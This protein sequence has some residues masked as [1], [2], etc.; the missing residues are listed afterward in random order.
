[1]SR[2]H[3][4][5]IVN[6]VMEGVAVLSAV[7]TLLPLA[8][9][10]AFLIYQGISSITWD[11]FTQMP[12]PVGEAGG[13]MANGIV[14]TLILIALASLIGVPVGI[15]AGVYVAEN[16]HTR[17]AW[18]ARFLADVLNGVPSIVIGVFAYTLLVLPMRSFSAV[19]GGFALGIMMLPV[20]LRTTEEM[21][22]LVPASLR[23]AALALGIPQWKVTVQIALRTAR[24]G[25]I[26]GV[27]L[28]VARIGGETAPLLFTAFGN[29][30]WSTRLDEPI[31]A[32]PLQ[33]F[34]YAISPYD[35][36]H[37]Q[38]WAGALVLVSLILVISVV[39]RTASRGHFGVAR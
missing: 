21:L 10:L 3:R 38:A 5:Q 33:I 27:M 4:R 23:E 20:V 26:T 2:D 32:L 18:G 37:A 9:I 31:A 19:A 22:K 13:G 30:F 8:L 12:A 34:T 14:G 15:A 7:V 11:F 35:T 16:G 36:W 29:Q 25:I 6:R 24:A 39:A 17:L 28:A 1:M